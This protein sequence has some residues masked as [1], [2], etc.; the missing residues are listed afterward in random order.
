MEPQR[1]ANAQ[2]SALKMR[3][4]GNKECFKGV[5]HGQRKHY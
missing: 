1:T 4:I 2:K 3:W 5:E